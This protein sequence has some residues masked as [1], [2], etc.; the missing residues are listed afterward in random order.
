MNQN[1][2]FENHYLNTFNVSYISNESFFENKHGFSKTELH[3][4]SVP[5][6]VVKRNKQFKIP[7]NFYQKLSE[8]LQHEN[9]FAFDIQVRGFKTDRSIKVEMERNPPLLSRIK[10][11]LGITEF[12]VKNPEVPDSTRLKQMLSSEENLTEL[13]RQRVKIA[14]AEG[15]L[16]GNNPAIKTGKA[17]KYFKIAQQVL[18][19]VIFLAIVISLMASASGS[20]FR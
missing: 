9:K 10:N 6:L 16:L 8:S 3:K 18:T 4:K 5:T 14:F 13:E 7:Q 19:V 15:Y 12:E 17:A 11:S 2:L 20:M 1:V